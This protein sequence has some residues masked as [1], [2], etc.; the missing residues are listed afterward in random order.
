MSIKFNQS[1]FAVQRI[2]SKYWLVWAPEADP[3]G[4][5]VH[6]VAVVEEPDYAGSRLRS[7]LDSDGRFSLVPFRQYRTN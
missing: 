1:V 3:Y 2:E 4:P 6:C 5:A 7:D